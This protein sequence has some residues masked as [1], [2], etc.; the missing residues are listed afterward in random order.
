MALA[1]A[2]P[3]SV[4]TFTVMLPPAM[5]PLG[6]RPPTAA[7]IDCFSRVGVP[8]SQSFVFRSH[9]ASEPLANSVYSC[10]PDAPTS[11]RQ[12]NATATPLMGMLVMAVVTKDGVG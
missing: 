2:V 1:T 8:P 12:P 6:Q 11:A 9:A 5:P 4:S 10:A 3:S 7:L